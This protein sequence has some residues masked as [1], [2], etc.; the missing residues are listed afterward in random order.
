[1]AGFV[2]Q[3]LDRFELGMCA[4]LL[5]RKQFHVVL[6]S[7]IKDTTIQVQLINFINEADLHLPHKLTE[8]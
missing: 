2:F 3:H 5:S 8:A 4:S 6:R 1:M 7:V